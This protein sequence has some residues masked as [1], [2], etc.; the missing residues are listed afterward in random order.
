MFIA[1]RE[2]PLKVGFSVFCTGVKA[3]VAGRCLEGR[4]G[5]LSSLANI[6]A[7]LHILDILMIILSLFKH[8]LSIIHF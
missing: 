3:N 2:S 6:I 5:L 8:F 1:S 7:H 4:S